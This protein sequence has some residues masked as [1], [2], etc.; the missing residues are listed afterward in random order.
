MCVCGAKPKNCDEPPSALVVEKILLAV[1][2]TETIRNVL[3]NDS[4][5]QNLITENFESEFVSKY[6]RT[7]TVGEPLHR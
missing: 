4:L 3:Q 6:L 7:S 2:S 5:S 1:G